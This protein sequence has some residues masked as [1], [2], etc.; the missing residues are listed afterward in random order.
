MGTIFAIRDAREGGLEMATQTA[1]IKNLAEQTIMSEGEKS[2][3]TSGFSL[4]EHEL[5]VA[6]VHRNLSPS[7]L[8]EHAIRFDNDASIAENGA[9]VAYSG[10]KTGALRK[11]NA[12]SSIRNPK[13]TF[14][15]ER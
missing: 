1:E 5:S 3:V 9:L 7:S 11:T 4:K 15:G 2:I 8:Y 6:Q 12:W 10:A 13:R 14:G